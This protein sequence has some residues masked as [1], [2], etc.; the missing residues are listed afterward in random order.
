MLIIYIRIYNS[1][2]L[3]SLKSDLKIRALKMETV[4]SLETLTSLYTPYHD[5]L[6]SQPWEPQRSH[7]EYSLL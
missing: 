1:V 7:D 4:S 5:T 2:E 3:G 6:E